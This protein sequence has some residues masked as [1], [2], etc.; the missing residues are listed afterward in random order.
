MMQEGRFLDGGALNRIVLYVTA[1]ME[2]KSSMGVIVAAADG[3][4][5]AGATRR[6]DCH[7][8]SDEARRG[9]DGPG[10]ARE[11]A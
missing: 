6:G 10:D 9:R 2:V 4:R 8:G 5:C 1:L 11:P 7:G 3:R